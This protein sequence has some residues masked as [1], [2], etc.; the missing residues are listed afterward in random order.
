VIQLQSDRLILRKARIA[1]LDDLHAIY[2]DTRVMRLLV[3]ATT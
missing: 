3:H 2:S 1:D